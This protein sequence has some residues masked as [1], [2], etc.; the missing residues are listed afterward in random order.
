MT[1]ALVASAIATPASF[2]GGTTS[3]AINTSGSP[4]V[5]LMVVG[6]SAYQA[7]IG[8]VTIAD[9]G[10]N[11]WTP[12]TSKSANKV[13]YTQ[14]YYCLNPNTSAAHT[15]TFTTSTGNAS[16]TVAVAAFSGVATSSGYDQQSGNAPGVNGAST[17]QPGSITP[18]N[19]NS[20]FVTAFCST[21]NS[22]GTDTINSSFSITNQ[23]P[24]T[25]GKYEGLALA[26]LVQS[27]GPTGVN[28]TWTVPSAG[29]SDLVAVMATFNP[30]AA[31][32]VTASGSTLSMMGVG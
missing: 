20:L 15:V 1:I 13:A 24:W 11:T 21:D 29:S 10:L 8:T 17:V 7:N 19:A 27:G 5:T 18:T 6:I 28:P 23:Q 9:T 25:S 30:G 26:Y 12:L 32:P 31:P 16:G 14:L 4:T 2:A 22:S 3:P